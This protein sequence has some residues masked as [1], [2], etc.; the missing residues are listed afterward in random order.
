MLLRPVVRA[1]WPWIKPRLLAPLLLRRRSR[2]GSMQVVGEL[3]GELRA[4]V[5]ALWPG[6]PLLMPK[7]W[8]P[9]L[10]GVILCTLELW[11]VG[12]TVAGVP[13]CFSKAGVAEGELIH[14]LLQVGL[15]ASAEDG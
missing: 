6:R 1:R 10:S 9:R 5:L 2:A 11:L 15:Q 14:L 8:L 12:I 7:P 13:H 3:V 4:R